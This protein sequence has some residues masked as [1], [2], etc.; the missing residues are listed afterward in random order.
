MTVSWDKSL[1]TSAVPPRLTHSARS[2]VCH[3]TPSPLTAGYR[4]PYSPF[5]FQTTLT[6]PFRIVLRYCPF[7]T[8]QLSGNAV[9]FLLTLALRFSC[10]TVTKYNT[11]LFVCQAVKYFFSFSRGH[12]SVLSASAEHRRQGTVR[13]SERDSS[14]TRARAPSR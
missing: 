13:A 6:S 7:T 10:S 9:S 12:Q 5:G 14:R 1:K 8:G 11:M 3:H 4:Q 2:P